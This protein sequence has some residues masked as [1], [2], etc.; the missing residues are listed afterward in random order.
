METGKQI[1]KIQLPI[2]S[3]EKDP[4]AFVYN[5]NKTVMLTIPTQEIEHLF[6]G[7]TS[8]YKGYFFGI[9]E[10]GTIRFLPG[11]LPF[12]NW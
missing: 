7:D 12:Q 1:F 2:T 11:K 4:P 5:E 10:N 6:E 8:L 3:S 9:I